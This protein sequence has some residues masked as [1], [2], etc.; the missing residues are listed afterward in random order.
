MQ[1]RWAVAALLAASTLADEKAQE[2]VWTLP[3]T[4]HAI[5]ALNEKIQ[6]AGA[7]C[8]QNP[9]RHQMHGDFLFLDLFGPPAWRQVDTFQYFTG[10]PRDEWYSDIY[11]DLGGRG[12]QRDG[13]HWFPVV[14]MLFGAAQLP[15][16]TPGE[17][18]N[19][20]IPGD[21]AP[22][23]FNGN[24]YQLRFDKRCH[25][26]TGWDDRRFFADM[27]TVLIAN[28]IEQTISTSLN[29]NDPGMP[30]RTCEEAKANLPTTI[31]FD[32]S[33]DL[34]GDGKLDIV[35]LKNAG[36]FFPT[37]YLSRYAEPGKLVKAFKSNESC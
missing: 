26:G 35:F 17:L 28:G 34:D 16:I 14:G 27:N 19:I 5:E 23:I 12:G 15:G 37:V 30:Y 20:Q 8:S 4:V 22:F 13:F 10:A 7:W 36:G 25:E 3:D 29:T 31:R 11:L 21:E 32:F 2:L 33:G 1:G 24:T 9:C 18:T 6:D